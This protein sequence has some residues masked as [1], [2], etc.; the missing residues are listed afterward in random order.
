MVEHI[1]GELL[2]E[3]WRDE[4]GGDQ[5]NAL[6]TEQARPWE[7]MALAVRSEVAELDEEYGDDW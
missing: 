4:F 3:A 1:T 2:Y 5:W 6:T 7:D